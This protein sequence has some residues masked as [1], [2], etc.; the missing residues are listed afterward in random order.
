MLPRASVHQFDGFGD[1]RRKMRER[2]TY[3]VNVECRVGILHIWELI[4]GGV[5]EGVRS[6]R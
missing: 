3:W 1:R 5:Y 2:S 6:Q 4:F